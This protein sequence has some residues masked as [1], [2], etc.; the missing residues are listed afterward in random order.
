M[1]L[2]SQRRYSKSSVITSFAQLNVPDKGVN[3]DL[4][5]AI[6]KKTLQS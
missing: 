1:F 4:F 5:P 2:T 6:A 3:N